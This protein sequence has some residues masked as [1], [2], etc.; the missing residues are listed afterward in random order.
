MYM[1]V[2]RTTHMV[3]ELSLPYASKEGGNNDIYNLNVLI[4]QIMTLLQIMV[5]YEVQID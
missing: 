1:Y 3:I 2:K 5:F 4:Y